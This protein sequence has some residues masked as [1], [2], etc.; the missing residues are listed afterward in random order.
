MKE[1]LEK[2]R[3]SVVANKILSII[4]GDD[5]G[6]GKLAVR[7][8]YWWYMKHPTDEMRKSREY[9]AIKRDAILENLELL[10]DEKSKIIYESLIKFR[11]DMNMKEHPGYE[12]KQYFVNGIVKLSDNEIF[13][14]CGGFDGETSVEFIREC[15]GKYDKI[16][17]FE[18]DPK[19]RDLLGEKLPKDK[20]I[21]VID[22]GLWDKTTK[23]SFVSSGDSVSRVI[24]SNE[25]NEENVVQIPVTT[26]DECEMC[27]NATFIKMD[28]EG[29]EMKALEGA[30]NT[31]INKKPKLAI[32][33]YHSDSD[34]I[35]IIQYIHNL[36]PDYRLY[37]R[38]HSVGTI[39]TVLYAII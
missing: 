5:K 33:I 2:L 1:V 21:V 18:P 7:L 9:F 24:E 17:I 16:Y 22:K 11:C 26:I 36:V 4:G 29:A 39:E 6:V 15:Q 19:C 31:I 35:N 3:R 30:K 13:L 28:I 10:A 12:K 25:N 37:V 38:H 27:K 32:A 14:D 34:M 8:M 23:L 20:R